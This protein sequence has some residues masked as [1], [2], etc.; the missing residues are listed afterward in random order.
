MEKMEELQNNLSEKRT[1]IIGTI[2]ILLVLSI[3]IL[4]FFRIQ[5]GKENPNSEYEDYCY[6]IYQEIKNQSFSI[7]KF[8]ENTIVFYDDEFNETGKLEYSDYN[9]S[10]K[11]IYIE[12]TED[13]M[14]FWVKGSLDDGEGILIIKD[15]KINAALGG[16]KNLERAGST[17]YWFSTWE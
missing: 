12:N 2:L 6:Q 13:T 3:T 4:L 10:L 11:I 8:Q 9:S 17:S 14:L 16:I 1:V 5:R 15:Q 7:A